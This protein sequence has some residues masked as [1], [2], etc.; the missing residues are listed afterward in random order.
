MV[1]C[2][3]FIRYK[4]CK[5]FI[6]NSY[7]FYRS[8]KTS[9]KKNEIKSVKNIL[10]FSLLNKPLFPGLSYILNA[11]KS[12]IK[13]LENYK[14]KNIYV[15]LF[16]NKKSENDIAYDLLSDQELNTNFFLK[17]KEG[18]QNVSILNDKNKIIKK[19][20]DYITSFSD[21]YEYGSIGLIKK[22]LNNKNL[23]NIDKDDTEVDNSM[24]PTNLFKETNEKNDI[25]NNYI[26]RKKKLFYNNKTEK[27]TFQNEN[28]IYNLAPY[29][30][31]EN[32]CQI[33]VDVLERIK[34]NKWKGNN[35]GEIIIAN[36]YNENKL[37]NEENETILKKIKGYQLEIIEKIKEIIKI[38]NNNSYEYNILLKYYNT[39]NV[40]NL[41]NF[42]G[43]ITIA[44]NSNVQ[45]MLEENNIEKRLKKCV[46][47]LNED[48]YLFKMKTEIKIDLENKFL[49]E[50]K[51]LLITEQ[52]NLLK[53][54]IG[55]EKTEHEKNYE[56]FINKYNNLIKNNLEENI[57]THILNEITKFKFYNENNTDYS[58]AYQY[59]TTI[60]NIPY[61]KYAKLNNELT[62]CETIFKNSHYG[63]D[64][65]KKYIYEYLSIY[66]LNKN[67]KIK[68]KILLLL[69]CPGT[70]KTSICR[71]ISKCLNIPYYIIN[72]NNINN[73]N[74]LIGH[75]KTYVNSYEGKIISALINTQVMNPLIILDEFD[76]IENV[77][78]NNNIY[79]TFLNIFDQNQNQIFKDQY[80]NFPIDIS[81]IFF[82]C[83]ANSINNI[84]DM[85]L[86]RM[87]IINV[88]PYTNIDKIYIYK[89]YLKK[90]LELE[91]NISDLHIHISDKMLLY[92][93]NNY[94][95]ENGIR[96]FY[97]ILYDIY[98]KRAY[99]LLRGET[100]CV[101]LIKC[102]NE[103]VENSCF[104]ISNK[105]K[106]NKK[107]YIITDFINLDNNRYVK[108]G[109][110]S[111]CS[112]PGI[113]KSIAFTNNGGYIITI[114]I[115]SLSKNLLKNSYSNLNTSLNL[116]TQEE[117]SNK[118]NTHNLDSLKNLLEKKCNYKNNNFLGYIKDDM[119]P[120]HLF[121]E[122][123]YQNIFDLKN[124]HVPFIY[125]QARNSC[126]SGL[127]NKY[128]N[129]FSNTLHSPQV[130]RCD[131]FNSKDK[132]RHNN[133][134]NS[135]INIANRQTMASY[136]CNIVITGNV[137]KIMQESIII[138]NTY[139]INI[140]NR[141]FSNFQSE[142]LHINLSECDLKKDG[143]SAGINFVTSILSY[144]LKVPVDNNLC[145]T[146]EL[147][148]NGNILRIGGLVEKIITAKNSGIQ[149]LI[150]PKDNY[151]E[152]LLIPK[153]I[154]NDIHILYAHHYYQIFNYIFTP[155]IYNKVT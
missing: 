134:K 56:T 144:Y 1:A 86:D 12:F 62:K 103:D 22:I 3:N 151:H 133:V 42:V 74:D 68:P 108:Q 67:K 89:N 148:L 50:K 147:T 63:L 90:K 32:I 71:T 49:K 19:D 4:E 111:H 23:N 96:Q 146:G 64:T 84:P 88:Y 101:H 140:L 72:M 59:I 78:N 37:K 99:M 29:S 36:R 15:G 85:L 141:I 73:M 48:I 41:I 125:E 123:E 94:T 135:E 116:N 92:I 8:S 10:C 60:L 153:E 43:N 145:M 55:H 75:R 58:S 51:E 82:I 127:Q 30:N 81:N 31:G 35:I 26:E 150:I 80:I 77:Y 105:T 16:F 139:S 149:T 61:N 93:I 46:E 118:S 109:N 122:N 14:K 7:L 143:P 95:K 155:K 65:V 33:F 83:T 129:K 11:D 113:T 2:L 87:N 138:A 40:N 104:S 34:I 5:L 120:D 130:E 154:K 17:G 27:E 52:I 24:I 102:M 66:I 18:K 115:S 152:Y 98:K 142:Y 91:T 97:Y 38:N 132:A 119:C 114:E 20:I 137:G 21:I 69:G 79:N 128:K 47:L 110:I 126:Q 112:K 53:K 44:K 54:K 28:E 124:E 45:K 100:S 107:N 136:D 6:K 76:K 39:K 106:Y 9:Y 121:N 13:I 25:K 57:S 131:M 70:G 117:M